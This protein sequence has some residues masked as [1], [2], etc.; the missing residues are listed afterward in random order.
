M[1]K[2]LLILVIV[3]IMAC[4]CASKKSGAEIT[5]TSESRNTV[6]Y[7]IEGALDGELDGNY[8]VVNGG[9]KLKLVDLTSESIKKEVE[10]EG[11]AWLLGYDISGDNIVW[12]DSRND[13]QD[14]SKIEGEYKINSDVF[15]YNIKTGQQKQLTN[16]SST[17]M[18][19]KVWSKYVIYADNR[20]DTVKDYPGKWSLYMYNLS[21]GEEKLISSTLAAH[22]TIN[23]S[24]NKIVW[25]DDR[26]FNGKNSLR[27]GDNVPENNKDIYLYDITTGK[28]VSVATGDKMEAKPDVSGDYIVYEDRNGGNIN[29]DI[30]LYRIS[31]KEKINITKD[32]Y[33]QGD[34]RINGDYIVWMDE[35]RGIST[36]DVFVNGKAPN[37]DIFMY[38][39]KNKKEYLLTGD[40]PQ[41]QPSISDGWIAY[42]LSRQV[43]PVV[44]V[45]KYK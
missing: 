14:P 15:V 28:E 1:R 6:E 40:E 4:G 3:A 35:R 32:K 27:G 39:I 16:D 7:S 41:I 30:I 29:A 19:P 36:N 8:L 5:N 25:E 42:T 10:L 26:N 2:N 12:A 21:T 45:I 11:K 33:N 38:D 13:K 24:D 44:E 18:N 23:I 31:T 9:N 43:K 17:Q 37:S 34:A 22:S 20:N